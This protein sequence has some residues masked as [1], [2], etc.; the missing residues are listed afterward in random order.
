MTSF[1][2]HLSS[3]HILTLDVFGEAFT[4]NLFPS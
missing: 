3:M 2:M 1:G 4:A